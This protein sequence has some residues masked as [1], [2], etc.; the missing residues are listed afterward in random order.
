MFS[1][2]SMINSEY[3]CLR[4]I[5]W[6][7]GGR[8]RDS[9]ADPPP[10]TEPHA[11][12]HPT[13]PSQNQEP[14]APPTEPPGHPQSTFR[15]RSSTFFLH[16]HSCRSPICETPEPLHSAESPLESSSQRKLTSR[17]RDTQ[18]R[19]ETPKSLRG[20]GRPCTARLAANGMAWQ[21]PAPSPGMERSGALPSQTPHPPAAFSRQPSSCPCH[22]C[23]SPLGEHGTVAHHVASAETPPQPRAGSPPS[24]PCQLQPPAFERHPL[25]H[26]A[27]HCSF[28]P[29]PKLVPQ[30]RTTH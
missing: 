24:P 29:V 23:Q 21:G 14:D 5:Y 8:G 30:S 16:P 17:Q 13:T 6:G 2:F 15:I 9:Q 12:L 10:S 27:S 19:L 28:I 1:K 25:G 11:G 7:A 26:P 3:F 22:S 18:N 20:A 4:C